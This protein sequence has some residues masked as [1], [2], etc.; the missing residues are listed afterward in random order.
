M[1]RQQEQRPHWTPSWVPPPGVDPQSYHGHGLDPIYGLTGSVTALPAG[2]LAPPPAARLDILTH[3]P[4]TM[5]NTH[6]NKISQPP[7]AQGQQKDDARKPPP[8]PTSREPSLTLCRVYQIKERMKVLHES[9][10]QLVEVMKECS[11]TGTLPTVAEEMDE[12]AQQRNQVFEIASAEAKRCKADLMALHAK[13]TPENLLT[14]ARKAK[15]AAKH[16]RWKQKK[17]KEMQAYRDNTEQRRLELHAAIDKKWARKLERERKKAKR[18]LEKDEQRAKTEQK[19]QRKREEKQMSLLVQRLSQL[20][21][22]RRERLKREGH[23]F[24]EED[25]EFYER[26]RR[27]EEELAA[28]KEA[29][30]EQQEKQKQLQKERA[31]IRKQKRLQKKQ[32]LKQ[33]QKQKQEQEQEQEEKKGQSSRTTESLDTIDQNHVARTRETTPGPHLGQQALQPMDSVQPLS[34]TLHGQPVIAAS[35]PNTFNAASHD[36]DEHAQEEIQRIR[37]L[38]SHYIVDDSME[39]G[40]CSPPDLGIPFPPSSHFWAA[41]LTT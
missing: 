11:V 37:L 18:Q 8:P 39:N 32:E 34:G 25:Q 40:S 1:S 28:R 29:N 16:K 21:V 31:E 41:L 14:A 30:K 12:S 3:I 35:A 20:R 2:R 5:M 17:I 10:E 24:P 38:W 22:L 13:L 6:H 9:L 19:R 33:K 23:F 26:I 15:R 7:S 27:Q 4:T 36:V